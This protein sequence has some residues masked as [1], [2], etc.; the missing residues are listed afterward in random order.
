[1]MVLP[2]MLFAQEV[3][4]EKR[5]L[6]CWDPDEPVPAYAYYKKGKPVSQLVVE[7]IEPM[8]CPGRRK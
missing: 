6:S 3:E 8:T 2:D 7:R 5:S 4:R 1:M